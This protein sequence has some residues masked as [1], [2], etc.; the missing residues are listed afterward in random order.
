MVLRAMLGNFDRT[1]QRRDAS[2]R[3]PIET[4]LQAEQQATTIRIATTG[5]IGD[6]IWSH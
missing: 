5:G 4:A 2:G 1:H 6:L 3:F